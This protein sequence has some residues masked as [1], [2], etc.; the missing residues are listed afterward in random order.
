MSRLPAATEVRLRVLFWLTLALSLVVLLAPA[1]TVLQ[2]KIWLTTW[3]PYARE[4]DAADLTRH[5]DK[6]VHL[7]LFALLGLL[8]LRPWQHSPWRSRTL[9]GLL[10]FAVVTE[11][12]QYYVPGRSASWADLLTDLLGLALGLWVWR[13]ARLA[14]KK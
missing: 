9:K 2:A 14:S 11:C 1:A 4:I 6:W 8:G 12:L 3:L 7:S 13:T 10:L 5:T